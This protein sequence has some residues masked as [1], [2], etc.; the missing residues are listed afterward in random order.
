MKQHSLSAMVCA[1]IAILVFLASVTASGRADASSRTISIYNIHTKVTLKVKYKENGKYIPEALKKIN[2]VMGDWRRKESTKMDP[3]LIDLM[4]EVHTELGSK[5]PIYL[6]SGYR[7]LK[8]NNLLRK[9]RGGQAKKSRHILGKAAD[10]HFPDISVRDLRNSAMIKQV[11]GVGYYPTSAIPFVHLDTGRV[12]HWPRMGRHELAAL[13]PRDRT[14]HIP[15]DG[16]RIRRGDYKIAMVKL[17]SSSRNAAQLALARAKKR[18]SGGGVRVAGLGG[19]PKGLSLKGKPAKGLLSSWNKKKNDVKQ[20]PKDELDRKGLLRLASLN[21]GK[22]SEIA[23]NSKGAATPIDGGNRP[24]QQGRWVSAPEYDDEHDDELSYS[25]F[26]VLPLMSDT[27]VS[28]DTKII[29]MVAP[30]HDK[31]EYLMGEP[32]RMIPL[33]FRPGLQYSQMLWASDFQGK[34]VKNI[35]ENRSAPK[36]VPQYP[37]HHLDALEAR[38]KASKPVYA[39]N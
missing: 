22:D 5:R 26:P 24:V 25:P 15:R 39:R 14:Y 18:L 20:K 6:I 7:S 4:W 2:F 33:R 32:T 28:Y 8:T 37:K 1:C 9:T 35:M 12:R 17:N 29:K 36:G 13:F 30:A 19:I 31:V 11:G 34:A 10:V 3:K 38:N 16:K 27:S 21:P 23:A